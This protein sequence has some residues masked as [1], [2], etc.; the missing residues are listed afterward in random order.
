MADV[1]NGDAAA[2]AGKLT[3]IPQPDSGVAGANEGPVDGAR[4]E[5]LTRRDT[6]ARAT[7]AR[8]LDAA[9]RLLHDGGPPALTVDGLARAVDLTKGA[10]LHHFSTKEAL[11]RAVLERVFSRADAEIDARAAELR[12]A[13]AWSRAFVEYAFDRERSRDFGTALQSLVMSVVGDVGAYPSV[14]T[15][16][17]RALGSWQ[18]RLEDDGVTPSSAFIVRLALDGLADALHHDLAAPDARTQREIRER[19]L[20]LV[21]EGA[22]LDLPGPV[23]AKGRGAARRRPGLATSANAMALQRGAPLRTS[24]TAALAVGLAVTAYVVTLQAQNASASSVRFDADVLAAIV[25]PL[26]IASLGIARHL[27]ATSGKPGGRRRSWEVVAVGALCLSFAFYGFAPSGATVAADGAAVT[28]AFAALVAARVRRY[29]GR[30]A[31]LIGT[32]AVWTSY[33]A[34]GLIVAARTP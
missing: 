7:R 8:L 20:A 6:A 26:L 13:R 12:G 34:A 31:L 2:R 1:R 18:R 10:V 23:Q 25:W 30:A 15:D 16:V 21:T 24:A 3:V 32:L 27:V 33:A 5:R 9:L 4:P 28:A 17:R 19:L 29:S 22:D 14:I 11:I